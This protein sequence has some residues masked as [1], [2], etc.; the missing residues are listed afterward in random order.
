MCK[1]C[2]FCNEIIQV[3]NTETRCLD[4]IK[5]TKQWKNQW[6]VIIILMINQFNYLI[7]LSLNWTN[8]LLYSFGK[9]EQYTE[10]E[11]NKALSVVPEDENIG[12]IVKHRFI[13]P[14]HG[15]A[16]LIRI[17]PPCVQ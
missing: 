8:L 17:L 16:Y 14:L 3:D 10:D 12:R 15:F 5:A 6:S 13:Q 1:K 4:F 2:H 9:D 7:G 11:I